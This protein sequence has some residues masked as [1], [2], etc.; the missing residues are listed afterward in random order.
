MKFEEVFSI[1]EM[2]ILKSISVEI[3]GE[4]YLL[5]NGVGVTDKSRNI[6]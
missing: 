1:E 2:E 4:R 6:C 3:S 5:V